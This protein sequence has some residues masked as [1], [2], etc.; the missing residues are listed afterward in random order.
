MRHL[1]PYAKLHMVR[2]HEY[3]LNEAQ[4]RL[5][6]AKRAL[7]Q[8]VAACL[9]DSGG[10]VNTP[11]ST[12]TSTKTRLSQR[13]AGLAIVLQGQRRDNFKGRS[14]DPRARK[15]TFLLGESTCKKKLNLNAR[16]Y[17]KLPK[18]Y[19]DESDCNVSHLAGSTWRLKNFPR[20]T[21]SAKGQRYC[22]VGAGAVYTKSGSLHAEWVPDSL[23]FWPS[24]DKVSDADYRGN[25]NGDFF[26]QW[27]ERH[28]AALLGLVVSIWTVRPITRFSSTHLHQAAH[29]EL[30]SS[31]GYRERASR[32]Q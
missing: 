19:L 14:R 26:N 1:T 27:F 18:M 10:M 20:Y 21:S 17:H 3:F 28:C 9:A 22:I 23:E 12:R 25:F 24:H 6:P 15:V 5:D 29:A 30:S 16:R 31:N 4:Q 32:Y 11:W 13:I 7:H 2:A 8:R